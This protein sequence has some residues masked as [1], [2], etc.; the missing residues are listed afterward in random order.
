MA[1][2]KKV[3]N[4][5]AKRAVRHVARP[6][7]PQ[8]RTELYVRV[9]ISTKNKIR[10]VQALKGYESVTEATDKLLAAICDQVLSGKK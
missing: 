1:N 7:K 2:Q 5:A 8:K 4:G 10:K 3:I 9:R 6:A